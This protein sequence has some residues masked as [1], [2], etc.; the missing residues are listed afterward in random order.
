MIHNIFEFDNKYAEDVMT[1]RTEVSLLW[2]EESEEDWENYSA[3]Q[4]YLLSRMP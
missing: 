4:A 1:H 3:K 2:L